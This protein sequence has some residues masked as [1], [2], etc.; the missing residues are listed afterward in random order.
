MIVRI[1]IKQIHCIMIFKI[2]NPAL[3]T[4]IVLLSLLF[5]A[6]Y[7]SE[8]PGPIQEIQKEYSIVDFDRIEMGDAFG[9]T[10]EKGNFF[11]VSVRG[12]SR[13]IDDLSVRKEGSTLVIRYQENRNRKHTT[14]VTIK[15][16]EIVAANFS[17]ASDSRIS[18]FGSMDAFDLYL[19]GGSVCQLDASANSLHV[20]LSG[21]SYLNVRGEG[22]NLK[23]ELSGASTL[24]AFNF[25][26]SLADIRVSGASDGNVTVSDK[27]KAIASGASVISYHGNPSVTAD[28]SGSSTVRQD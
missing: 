24:K 12:D 8:D 26:V 3:H 11:E 4:S 18:G 25:P 6:C 20:V 13:N 21:A 15:M 27:L 9:I 23:G 17:G 2:K 28:V 7:Q 22:E 19:S 16:P 14:Y 1:V 10:V 5:S